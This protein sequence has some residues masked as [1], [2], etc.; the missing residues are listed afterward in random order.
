MANPFYTASNSKPQPDNSMNNLNQIYKMLSNSKNPI[1][2]FENIASNNPNLTPILNLLKNGYSPK[3][4]FDMMCQ[5]SGV[6]P[7]QFINSLTK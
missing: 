4:I 6:D 1:E 7:Q 3:Q 2:V 5:K